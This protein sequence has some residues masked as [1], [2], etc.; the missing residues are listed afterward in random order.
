MQ[1]RIDACFEKIR[2]RGEQ[3]FIAYIAAGDPSLARTVELVLALEKCGTDIVELGVP[4]SD[5]LADG[6]VNQL[7]AQRALEGGATV[8]GVLD[9]VRAVRQSSQVPIVLYTYLN[10]IF[11]FGFEKFHHAAAAAGVDGLLILDLPP[12]EERPNEMRSPNEIRHIRLV[13]PTTPPARMAQ[14]TAGAGG[15]IY[16]VSREGVT[17]EQTN[18]VASLGER[19]ALI[20][21]RT[22]LPV[23]VGFGISSAEQVREV[24]RVADAV[25]VGSAIVRQIAEHGK[26]DDLLSVVSE[27]VRPLS[28]ATKPRSPESTSAPP[29]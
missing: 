18:V 1:N 27:F 7:A 12:E 24:A 16:Y 15:F 6:I 4:F 8:R 28:A 10:P 2:G 19:I 5:P 22:D 17:G 14:L 26:S 23:A 13:A 21:A 29:D 9:C 25:V 3:A 20:R 11:Q